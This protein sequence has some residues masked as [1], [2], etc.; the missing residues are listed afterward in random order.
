MLPKQWT[1]ERLIP[2]VLLDRAK[3]LSVFRTTREISCSM[4]LESVATGGMTTGPEML[5]CVTC[6]RDTHTSAPSRPILWCYLSKERLRMLFLFQV[7]A[8]PPRV[9]ARTIFVIIIV[10]SLERSNHFSIFNFAALAN[11]AVRQN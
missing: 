2:L 3:G 10:Q 8:D 5:R 7:R 1:A 4:R 9:M 6:T 11:S